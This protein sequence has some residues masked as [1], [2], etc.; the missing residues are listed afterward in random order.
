LT[1]EFN[2]GSKLDEVVVE[3]PIGHRRRRADGIPL[4]E[5]K[6]RINLARRFPAKQ[7]NAILDVSLDQEKLEALPVNAYVDLY[8]I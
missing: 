1:V 7:Q 8:V 4:L 2:D 6:F 3:Y 5:K